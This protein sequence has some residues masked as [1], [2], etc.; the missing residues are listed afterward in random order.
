MV[1]SDTLR[2]ELCQLEFRADKNKIDHPPK[3]SKD[4]AD[5]VC[6]AVFAASQHRSTRSRG[7]YYDRDGVSE[8]VRTKRQMSLRRFWKLTAI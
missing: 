8:G 5:A 7:G 3:G 4:V 6:G 1:D 2:M